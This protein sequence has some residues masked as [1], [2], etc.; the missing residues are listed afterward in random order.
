MHNTHTT[1]Q[2]MELAV[3]VAALDYKKDHLTDEEHEVL[4]P[5]LK[6]AQPLL[7]KVEEAIRTSLL[8]LHLVLRWC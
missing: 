4:T 2:I 7:L 1:D 8:L 3:L 6:A 5:I